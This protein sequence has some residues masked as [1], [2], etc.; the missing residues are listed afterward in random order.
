MQRWWAPW[1]P[2]SD[3]PPLP[4]TYAS[5]R[6]SQTTRQQV[7][8]RILLT[9]PPPTKTAPPRWQTWCGSFGSCIPVDLACSAGPLSDILHSFPPLDFWT[10]KMNSISSSNAAVLVGP[11]IDIAVCNIYHFLIIDGFQGIYMARSDL[12]L[13]LRR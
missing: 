8:R 5:Q 2:A 12:I 6:S 4:T 9:T 11:K 13:D 10:S 3:G 7:R 1:V